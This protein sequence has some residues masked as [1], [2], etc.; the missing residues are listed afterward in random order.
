MAKTFVLASLVLTLIYNS[1]ALQRGA[2][3]A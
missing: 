1:T 2:Y 3:G